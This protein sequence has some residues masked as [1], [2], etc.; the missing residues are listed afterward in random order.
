MRQKRHYLNLNSRPFSLIANGEKSVEMRLFDEKR[1]KIAVGDE[2]V[3]KNIV[4]KETLNV[5]VEKLERYHSFQALYAQ[6]PQTLL[7]Y[8]NG[9][10]AD[11]RD[12]YT[13]Y[14]REAEKNYGV[15]AIYIRKTFDK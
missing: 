5:V 2:L 14:T 1:Q 7:G 4:T 11:Y 8:K 12:M 15:L 10:A 13:Y 6:I 9:E 3:F